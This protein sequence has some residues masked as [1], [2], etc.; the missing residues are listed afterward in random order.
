[1]TDRLAARFRDKKILLTGSTGF[2][3]KVVLSTLLGKLPE[4]GKLVCLVRAQNDAA[5]EDRFLKDVVASPALDPV[6]EQHGLG[7][8]DFMRS[9]V[10]VR[11]ADVG[12]ERLGLDAARFQELAK[13]LD[14][15]IHCAGLV[16]FVPP[17]D[18]G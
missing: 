14:L 5:A 8:R 9:K 2:V 12:R 3:G 17:L 16:D 1:M 15:V 10:E 6:R 18:K 11:A 7:L 13:D 4:V